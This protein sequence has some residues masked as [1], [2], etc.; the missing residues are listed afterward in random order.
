[1][2]YEMLT[3]AVPYSGD[4]AMAI[5]NQHL[6]AAPALPSK[7]NPAIPPNIE[8]IIMKSI[9][10]DPKERYQSAES[11]LADLNN[12]KELDTSNVPRDKE[13]VTGVVTSRQIWILSALIALGF[14]VIFGLIVI[15]G[16]IGHH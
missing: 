1:M 14:I 10:K 12:Y 9:R 13:K 11:F 5:M 15:I 4:N 6:K 16:M 8:A 7:S 3:G 2:F